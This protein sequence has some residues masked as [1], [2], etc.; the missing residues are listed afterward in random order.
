MTNI[1]KPVWNAAGTIPNTANTRNNRNKLKKSV[2]TYIL[3][4]NPES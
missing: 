4:E 3:H 1:K 2:P